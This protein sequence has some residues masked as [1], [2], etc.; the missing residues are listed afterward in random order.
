MNSLL[1]HARNVHS[2][3][4]EDG[5]LAEIFTR[6]GISEGVFVDLGAGDGKTFSNTHSLLEAGWRGV[7]IDK[8]PENVELLLG[9]WGEFPGKVRVIHRRITERGRSSLD[10]VLQETDTPKDF[11][12]LSIDVDGQDLQIWRSLSGYLP[13][14]VVIEVNSSIPLGV[15]QIHG[16]GKQGAS[17]TSMRELGE[18]K[19]YLLACHTGNAV[20]VYRSLAEKLGLFDEEI[21]DPDRLF[22]YNGPPIDPMADPEG[23][24][25]VEETLDPVSASPGDLSDDGMEHVP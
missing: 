12:L 14:V 16:K 22:S 13:K 15:R 18:W 24:P 10:A 8:N 20:F 9:V 5:I 7:V 21:A 23:D 3:N 19:G 1:C 6:L 25:F 4:G 11:D 17:F 2:Q